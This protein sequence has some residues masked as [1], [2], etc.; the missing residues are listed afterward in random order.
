[1]RRD[2]V[3][4]QCHDVGSSFGDPVFTGLETANPAEITPAGPLGFMSNTPRARGAINKQPHRRGPVTNARWA[5]GVAAV[6]VAA[7][8]QR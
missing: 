4:A 7:D 5:G 6:R 3:R 1:V 2:A 8:C